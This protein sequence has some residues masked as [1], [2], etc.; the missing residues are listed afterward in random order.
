MRELRPLGHHFRRQ[1]PISFYYADFCCHR[2]SL[3]IEV[4][5]DLHF[6]AAAMDYDAR[7]DELLRREGYRV[8]RF[9]NLD[10]MRNIDGVMMVVLNALGR[11]S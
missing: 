8:L 3:V 5:G 10:V 11:P 2:S 7:R 9:T 1:V 6:E 4:D